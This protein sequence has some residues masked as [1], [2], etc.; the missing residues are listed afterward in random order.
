MLALQG[1][2][3]FVLP[4]QNENFGIAVAEALANGIPAIVTRGAPWPALET[5]H[6]GWWIQSGIEPLFRALREATHLSDMERRCM[7]VRGRTL[8]RREYD[9]DRIAVEMRSV[10]EWVLTQGRRPHTIHLD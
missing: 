10:Y 5:E 8:V 2:D 3:L 4:T 9:W 1:A 6:C 7:G